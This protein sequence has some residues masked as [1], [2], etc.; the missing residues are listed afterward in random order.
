[1]IAYTKNADN[2]IFL[3]LFIVISLLIVP[4]NLPK[5]MFYR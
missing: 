3:E 2:L 1:M 4:S 5:T